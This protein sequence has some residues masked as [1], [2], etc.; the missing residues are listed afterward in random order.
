MNFKR[1]FQAILPDELQITDIA[2]SEMNIHWEMINKYPSNLTA[3]KDTATALEKH[4]YDSLMLMPSIKPGMRVLDI[5]SGAGFPG[6]PLAICRKEASF[7]L[8]EASSK[9]SNF[10]NDVIN[11][12][13]LTNVSVINARAEQAGHESNLRESFDFVTARA[14]TSLPV[15]LEY[16]LPFLRIK[17][18]FGAMKGQEIAEELSLADNALFLLGGKLIASTE[19]ALPLF[20]HSRKIIFFEK[21][22]ATPTKYPRREGV[23]EKKPL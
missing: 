15:L 13:K 11:R 18:V 2:V 4:Y 20:K 1:E 22:V 14:V 21:I 19:Y 17:G 12:L 23:P 16:G 9:K 6:I 8:L 7:T 10:L 3:I 5:G